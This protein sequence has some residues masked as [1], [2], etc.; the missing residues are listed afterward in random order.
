MNKTPSPKVTKSPAK[1][2][3]DDDGETCPICF[4]SWEMS[5]QHRLVSLKCGHLF[6]NSCI[7]RY[8]PHIYLS[9]EF[10]YKSFII[11]QLKSFT[12]TDG[13]PKVHPAQKRV[14]H[15]KLVPPSKTY[16]ISMRKKYALST[17]VKSIACK[18]K[19][20]KKK[21]VCPS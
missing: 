8:A 14:R 5:G 12:H 2:D 10:L 3:E 1:M 4:D 7:R 18:S 15:V 16:E 17:K 19:S 20:K 13:L 6:G 11:T 9:L 21:C